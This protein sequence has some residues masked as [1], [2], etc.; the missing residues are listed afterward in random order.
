MKK[1]FASAGLSALGLIALGMLVPARAAAQDP[2]LTPII[3]GEAAPIV[4]RAITPKPKATGVQKFQG[5][6]MHANAA[7]V[8]V[9]AKGDNMTIE[10]FALNDATSA[11][12]L[13]II[14]KGGFQYGDKIT[15]YYDAQT[16]KALKFKG[17]P[18]RAL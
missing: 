3:A 12:M 14:D 5:T 6:V 18:S 2:I 7:Q 1:V 10:T 17:K 16:H 13:K 8:T 9:K 4:V 11:K 15:V